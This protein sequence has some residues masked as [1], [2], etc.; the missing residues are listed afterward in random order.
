MQSFTRNVS[1]LLLLAGLGVS[2]AYAQG[3]RVKDTPVPTPAPPAKAAPAAPAELIDINSA[4]EEVLK[5]LPGIDEVYAHKIVA[6][7]PYHSKA[8]LLNKKIVPRATYAK[9]KDKIIAKQS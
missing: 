4:D 3:S 2:A 7:R 8:E 6:G 5:T 1:T 9:I